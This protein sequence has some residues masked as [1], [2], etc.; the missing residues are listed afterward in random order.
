MGREDCR[1]SSRKPNAPEQLRNEQPFYDNGNDKAL[2]DSVRQT[3]GS[4]TGPTSRR[5]L[6]SR[7]PVQPLVRLCPAVMTSSRV[8]PISCRQQLKQWT[9]GTTGIS[10]GTRWDT[11]ARDC[12]VRAR[13]GPEE[14]SYGT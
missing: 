8:A 3:S 14:R 1:F 10:V 9:N 2:C 7:V 11:T 5:R 6:R 12:S 4:S 13:C